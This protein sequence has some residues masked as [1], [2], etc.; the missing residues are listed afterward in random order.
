MRDYNYITPNGQ[1]VPVS[2]MGT[3]TIHEILRNGL[4][5]TDDGQADPV[6]CA[7]E[8]LRIELVI[9]SLGL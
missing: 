1:R 5:V 4:E 8:R 6:E 7:M 2:Q 3:A 9:R